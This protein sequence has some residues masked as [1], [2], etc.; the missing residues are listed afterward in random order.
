[1]NF[2]PGIAEGNF[3]DISHT[4]TAGET[5]MFTVPG[6]TSLVLNKSTNADAEITAKTDVQQGGFDVLLGQ[7]TK[8]Q[9][10]SV[11]YITSDVATTIKLRFGQNN[12]NLHPA[13]GNGDGGA[14]ASTTGALSK[15]S[16]GGG[17][18]SNVSNGS[19]A[20]SY[21]LITAN[22]NRSRLWIK[23]TDTQS[24]TVLLGFSGETSATA[25]FQLDPGEAMIIAT[26]A[27]LEFYKSDGSTITF[28][29]LEEEV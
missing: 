1:M 17:G 15:P 3:Y 28:S 16:S 11:I 8:P 4:F 7:V 24:T 12:H 13:S 6:G 27:E 20:G 22:A 21:T 29:L 19:I 25:G 26:T 10:F 2:T 5:K 14:G 9:P 18:A 23:R